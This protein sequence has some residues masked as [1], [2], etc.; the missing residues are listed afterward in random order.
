[1]TNI[2]TRCAPGKHNPAGERELLI[3]ALRTAVARSRLI[4]NAL[5]TI[6]VSLRHNAVTTDE[7]MTWLYEERLLDLV[8]FGPT[9][10][11]T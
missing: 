9:G 3:H 1:M 8:H 2:A 5:E 10:A 6:G 7:A 11:S 4:T